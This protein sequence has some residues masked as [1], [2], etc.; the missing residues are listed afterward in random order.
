MKTTLKLQT[1]LYLQHPYLKGAAE[2]R[3]ALSMQTL[4]L[5]TLSAVG[6]WRDT[7]HQWAPEGWDGAGR[8][9]LLNAYSRT[10]RARVVNNLGPQTQTVLA[11]SFSI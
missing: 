9:C 3:V 2:F 11:M 5:G 6:Q 4:V 1:V 8:A 7:A 10:A